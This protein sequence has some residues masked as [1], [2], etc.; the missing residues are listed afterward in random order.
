MCVNVG[1]FGLVGLDILKVFRQCFLKLTLSRQFSPAE[2]RVQYTRK[3]EEKN[4][5]NGINEPIIGTTN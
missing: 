4:E 5:T 1:W 3:S 2:T